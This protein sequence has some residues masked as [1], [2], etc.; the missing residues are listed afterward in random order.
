MEIENNTIIHIK[1]QKAILDLP[2]I[3]VLLG[4]VA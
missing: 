2:Q 4:I 3:K 1:F